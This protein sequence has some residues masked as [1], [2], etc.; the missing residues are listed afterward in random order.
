MDGEGGVAKSE[1]AEAYLARKGTPCVPRAPG[2]QVAH[3]D[4]RAAPLRDVIHRVIEQRRRE[5]LGI[6]FAR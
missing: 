2:Q 3:I 1:E 5:V 4:R 6:P